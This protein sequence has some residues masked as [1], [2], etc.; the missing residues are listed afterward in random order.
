M[1]GDLDWTNSE[2]WHL[3]RSTMYTYMSYHYVHL[4]TLSDISVYRTVVK[5][6]R[7]VLKCKSRK[8][9]IEPRI[10]YTIYAT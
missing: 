3:S 2:E 10:V 1:F 6:Q 4:D 7:S 8:I 9:H 5:P